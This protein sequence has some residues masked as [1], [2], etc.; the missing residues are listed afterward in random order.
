MGKT[1]APVKGD[2]CL[3][4]T[5]GCIYRKFMLGK[6]HAECENVALR[7]KLLQRMHKEML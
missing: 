6:R 4:G 7:T 1:G 5:K 3:P 2:A